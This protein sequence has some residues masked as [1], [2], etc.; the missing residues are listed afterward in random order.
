MLN[1]SKLFIL[2]TLFCY[3]GVGISHAQV[4]LDTMPSYMIK[5]ESQNE[6]LTK[7]I[8]ELEKMIKDLAGINE[9]LYSSLADQLNIEKS[10]SDD[11]PELELDSDDDILN[12]QILDQEEMIQ[13]LRASNA[14]LGKKVTDHEQIIELLT[15]DNTNLRE[16]ITLLLSQKEK[17]SSPSI[18]VKPIEYEQEQSTIVST[19]VTEELPRTYTVQFFKSKYSNK[20]FPTLQGLGP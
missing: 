6:N 2:T 8:Q 15:L 17:N 13:E 1:L 9:K 12:K 19:Q 3:V 11:D 16:E 10:P 14:E 20:T 4:E 7:Q 5:L 18:K